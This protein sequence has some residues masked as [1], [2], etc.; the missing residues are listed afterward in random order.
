MHSASYAEQLR[1]DDEA[2]S[3]GEV[4]VADSRWFTVPCSPCSDLRYRHNPPLRQVPSSC[5]GWLVAWWGFLP[6]FLVLAVACHGLW[7]RALRLLDLQLDAL[8]IA[9]LVLS[10]LCLLYL[11]GYRGFHK[12]W[13]P[14]TARRSLLLPL[15]LQVDCFSFLLSL[16]API[17]AMGFIYAPLRRLIISYVLTS[18]IVALVVMVRRLPTP[19]HEIV[20]CA[21]AFGLSS[22][23]LSFL[24]YYLRS[25][26]TSQLPPDVDALRRPASK[27]HSDQPDTPD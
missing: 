24:F 6:V 26:W 1:N 17:F 12:S 13:A 20:D 15:G 23:T 16:L 18:A 10:S 27:P 22:G 5:T 19:W 25:V 14:V 4:V 3:D 7:S 9:V 8:Q 2:T 11:E 21:V